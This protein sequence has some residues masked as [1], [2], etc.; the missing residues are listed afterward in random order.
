MNQEIEEAEGYQAEYTDTYGGQ[1]NYCWVKRA[2]VQG[3]NLFQALKAAR[4]E[5][6]LTGIK[7]D[8]TGSFGDAIWWKPRGRNT[9]L[10]VS[11]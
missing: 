11:W 6:G 3:E 4:K 5:F 8:I 7:G 9:I 10:M 1:A 2:V